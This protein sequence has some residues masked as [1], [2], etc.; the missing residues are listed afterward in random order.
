MIRTRVAAT[1]TTSDIVLV[2][3]ATSG[4]NTAQVFDVVIR[5]DYN[6]NGS[7]VTT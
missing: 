6:V 7:S 5:L 4:I 2:N 3:G 1:N